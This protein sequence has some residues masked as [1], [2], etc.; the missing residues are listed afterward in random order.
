MAAL[1]ESYQ[2]KHYALDLT[3]SQQCIRLLD[4]LPVR[5]DGLIRCAMLPEKQVS[6]IDSTRQ[7]Y[8]AISY[9]CGDP[10]SIQHIF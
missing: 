10:D 3:A 2:Y 6:L 7:S 4:L 1:T 5:Q 8:T 9:E